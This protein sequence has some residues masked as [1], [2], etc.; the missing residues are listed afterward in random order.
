MENTFNQNRWW[1]YKAVLLLSLNG[2]LV[3]SITFASF[4]HNPVGYVTGNITFAANAIVNGSFANFIDMLVAV[5]AF[6]L[7]SILS[8]LIIPYDNFNRDSNYNI[9]FTIEA[10]LITLGMLGL[11]WDISTTKYLLAIALGL[12]N[13][14]STFYGRSI[15]RTTH[16]TGTMTDL[17]LILAHKF[18][19]GNNLPLWR[20]YIYL[21][22]ICG[23]F[24]GS[25]VG[26]V[27][28]KLIGYYGLILSII[29]CITMI[30]FKILR[31][32]L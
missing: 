21:F 32:V 2:G 29:A 16:L 10:G 23:F 18:L 4:V 28:F 12:Q 3:N 15:I 25:V 9:V 1:V 6:L 7:G 24:S 13:G 14:A 5:G 19:K 31:K 11:I 17:G 26:I 20:V 30:R 27:C 22:L 8:G